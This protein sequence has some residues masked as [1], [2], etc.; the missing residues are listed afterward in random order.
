MSPEQSN[1]VE[2][3]LPG[4]GIV[5]VSGLMRLNKL[6]SVDLSGNYI[7]NIYPLADVTGDG[8]INV[9]DVSKLYAVVKKT[10]SLS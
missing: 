6:E 4:Q 7:S 10:V 8:R 1:S 3:S 9:G 5:D 2:L